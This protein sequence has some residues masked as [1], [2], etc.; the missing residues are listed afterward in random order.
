MSEFVI[1]TVDGAPY[2]GWKSMSV[3][4]TAKSPERTFEV[5]ASDAGGLLEQAF[6][7]EPGKEVELLATGTLLVKGYID[8]LEI[9]FDANAHDLSVSGGSKGKDCV[10][11]SAV[12]DTGEFKDKTILNIANELDKFGIGFESDEE[13]RKVT[14]R[15]NNGETMHKALDRIA[16]HQGLFLASKPDGSVNITRH[17]K[18]KHAGGIVEGV[19]LLAGTAHFSEQNRF[20]D[21]TVKGQSPIG[22]KAENTQIKGEVKDGQI[23][24]YR[25]KIFVA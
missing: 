18:N 7:F 17:G 15:L 13:L 20:S 1:L 19:N 5:Q 10:E 22:T 11:C 9:S 14:F 25:P 21:Y 12:H 16:R 23:K 24:R 2:E 6:G 4:Y 3:R 8:K